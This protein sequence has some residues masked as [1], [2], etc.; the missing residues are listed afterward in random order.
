M[1][2]G[3]CRT[4]AP[5][6]SIGNGGSNSYMTEPGGIPMEAIDEIWAVG[7]DEELERW[8]AGEPVQPA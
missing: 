2:A 6:W 8:L 1:R 4:P 7:G 3:W 5:G